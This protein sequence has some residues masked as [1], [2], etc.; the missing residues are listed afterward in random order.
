[1]AMLAESPRTIFVGQAVAY[2]GQAAFPT[3]ADVPMAKRIEM[4]VAEDFQMGFCTGLA[5]HGYVPVCFYPRWDFLLMAAGQ[6]VNH[7]DKIQLM[8][9]FRP[10]VIIR[11]AIGRK[12]P[13]DPGPQHTGD[14]TQAFRGMLK[15]VRVM[16]LCNAKYVYD[17]Y[18]E[19]LACD[20]SVIL[21]EHMDRYDS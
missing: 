14:Y 9:G 19:A 6:L 1:M 4:P 8:G 5:L 16:E 13:L 18:C 12:R 10:K 20:G 15:T 2:A 17:S 7:L 3:F 11:T 21:V